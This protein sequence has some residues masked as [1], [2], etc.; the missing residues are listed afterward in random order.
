M[1]ALALFACTEPAVEDSGDS[2]VES[3]P[4]TDIQECE[5]T[6]IRA[7]TLDAQEVV[8]PAHVDDIWKLLLFCEDALQTGALRISVDPT[9]FAAFDEDV[10]TFLVVGEGTFRMQSGRIKA[11]RLVVVE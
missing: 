8:E 3:R 4:D 6:E 11:E 1:I 2:A 5:T 9:N 7:S 10:A